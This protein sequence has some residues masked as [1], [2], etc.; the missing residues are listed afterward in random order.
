M[1][2]RRTFIF[3]VAF[4]VI[5]IIFFLIF[6][7]KMQQNKEESKQIN[8]EQKT[9][10]EKK[11]DLNESFGKFEL[12][13]VS[14][15]A[16]EKIFYENKNIKVEFDLNDA[17]IMHS[18]VWKKDKFDLVQ[19]ENGAGSLRMKF[20]SWENEL[21]LSNLTGGSNKYNFK[22]EGNV[23]IFSCNLKKKY[24]DL[25]YTIEKKYEFFDDDNIYKVSIKIKNNKNS[26]NIFDNSGLAF[27]LGLGPT[28][29]VDSRE[30]KNKNSSL[31]NTFAYFNSKEIVNVDCPADKI[32]INSDKMF[33]GK[34]EIKSLF[35]TW[36][37]DGP[38][39]WIAINEQ[40]FTSLI[41]PDNQNYKYFFDYR[42]KANLNYFCGLSRDAKISVVDSTFFIYIGPKINSYLNKYENN[43]TL[44]LSKTNIKKI[45]PIKFFYIDL[46][47]EKLLEFLY[48]LVKNYGVAIIILTIII[49]LLL[50]P[51]T[52][53][54]MQ[55]QEKMSKLQPKLKELQTKYK[56][57]PEILNKE[58][59]NLYKKEGIN[60]LGGCLPMLL[61]MPI[62][63]AM[64]FVLNKMVELK[65]ASFLFIRDLSIP[66]EIIK[67]NFVIPLVN[68]YSLNILPIIMSFTQ[69]LSTLLTPGTQS[70]KQAQIMMWSMT[71]IFFFIFYNISSGL[72][73]YWTIMNILNL[74]QQL[75]MNKLKKQKTINA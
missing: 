9:T 31:K 11:K 45:N 46:G 50:F 65:G 7:P 49:K 66:D 29:G 27:S 14:Q 19:G 68:I 18:W 30:T 24:E 3:I 59:M 51:L 37:M 52:Y 63:F 41:Y 4:A 55:S 69:V 43:P 25:I 71:I 75:F 28:L 48:L 38:S 62:L 53:K 73:L 16:N 61:Q 15:N 32:I 44:G 64:Y 17:I 40:Y 35:T 47:I 56:D 22:R 8:K 1:D 67:F 10:E 42:D 60:P 54:S 2:E 13:N 34:T 57:K 74:V 26:E 6:Q 5:S 20:G 21:T 23:F 39:N 12:I 72:V 33:F 58:T 70:N 36:N